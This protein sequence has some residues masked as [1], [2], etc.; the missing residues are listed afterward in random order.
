MAFPCASALDWSWHELCEVSP[1]HQRIQ[2]SILGERDQQG[3]AS[4]S[5]KA[6]AFAVES[7]DFR[8]VG[9]S[10]GVWKHMEAMS[11][12]LCGARRAD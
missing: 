12:D 4:S 9:T 10:K 11:G 5:F 6:R 3:Y 7:H 8:P 1:L 2:S